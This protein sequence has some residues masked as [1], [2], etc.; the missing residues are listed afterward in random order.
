MVTSDYG[1]PRNVVTDP[2]KPDGGRFFRPTVRIWDTADPTKPELIS[3][4]H[5]P[6]GWRNPQDVST[7]HLNRGIMENGKTW[8]KTKSFPRTIE[9]KGH[10]SGSMCGGGVFFTPDL[11]K[12]EPDSSRQWTQVWDDGFSLMT[13]RNGGLDAWLE[14]SGPCEGGAWHQVS[15]NNRWLFRVVTGQQANQEN[16][17]NRGQPVKILYSLDIAPLI[18]SAQDGEVTC[19]LAN[20]LDLDDDTNI[21][22][23]PEQAFAKLKAGEQVAD[24]PKLSSTLI[25]DDTTSGGPHW[26]AIDNHSLTPD[27]S[28]TRLVFSDYFVARSGIDGNHRLYAVDIDPRTGKMSY[29]E[30]WRD[31]QTGALG[32]DFNRKDWPGNRARATTSRTRWCGSAR[33]ASARGTGRAWGWSPRPPRGSRPPGSGAPPGDSARGPGGPVRRGWPDRRSSRRRWIPWLTAVALLAAAG[34]ARAHPSL[35]QSAPAGGVVADAAPQ[36]IV[37]SFTE[38]VEPAGSS[39]RL[40]GPG[41]RRVPMGA[42]AGRGPTVLAARPRAALATGV[43]EARWVALGPDGHT[44][45]G[46]FRFGVP[47]RGGAAPPDVERLDAPGLAGAQASP[48]DPPGDVAARWLG[49]VAAGV[50]LAGALLRWRVGAAVPERRWSRLRSGG[51][52][53]ALVA[54]VYAVAAAAGDGAGGVR[55]ALLGEPTGQLAL[56]RLAVLAA[57]A[58]LV[59][60]RRLPRSDAVLG[61]AGAGALYTHALDGHLQTVEDGVALAYVAQVAH[62]LAAGVWAGGLVVLAT[63]AAGG[64]A[65]LRAFAAIAGAAV[66]VLAGTGSSPPCARSTSGTSCAGPT[67][68]ASSW[69]SRSCSSCSS[70]RPGRPCSRCGAGARCAGRCA[71]RRP[72]SS[73]SS[74]SPRPSPASCRGGG[75]RR[76]RSAATSWRGSAS[77]RSRPAR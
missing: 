61:A 45:S 37:L 6:R 59:V 58:L 41:G 11:T 27:G 4:A 28:P 40:T 71:A 36:S 60:A 44:I 72:A 49:I 2:V 23:E 33:R 32:T 8:P 17:Q 18:R 52:A 13:A 5:M 14:D 69:R 7:M 3:V 76:R 34:P 77:G 39:I 65:A 25:V 66:V 31:E 57:V 67:T 55:D 74:C 1:E 43:Y 10:F 29:D 64:R 26:A 47:G 24:C 19:D 56:V 30:S 50:L 75:S 73:W 70:R 48:G 54:A 51:L 15:R 53:A 35:L 38:E 63:G 16:L 21:D 68:A 62:V 46:R 9:S 20:G 42:P 12:L 22:I